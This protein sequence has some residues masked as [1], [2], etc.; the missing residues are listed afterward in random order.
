MKES[1]F[2]A[3]V[4][5]RNLYITHNITEEVEYRLINLSGVTI[6]RTW[7]KGEEVIDLNYLAKGVYILSNGVQSKKII[8]Q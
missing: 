2:K 4:H 3:Y 5:D 7:T 8:L 1:D 6:N